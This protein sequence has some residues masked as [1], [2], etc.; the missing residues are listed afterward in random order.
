[1][2]KYMKRMSIMAKKSYKEPVFL[3]TSSSMRQAAWAG[4]Y[5]ALGDKEK[6]EQYVRAAHAEWAKE[7][8]AGRRFA[9]LGRF[10]RDLY[11]ID[12]EKLELLNDAYLKAI[13][14]EVKKKKNEKGG[15]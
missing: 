8:G 3:F 2:N 1:M 9:F 11:E 14:Q 5:S 12:F 10:D 7:V 15:K 6:A 4:W 13:A